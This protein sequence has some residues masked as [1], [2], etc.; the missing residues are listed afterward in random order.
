[1]TDYYRERRNA[2]RLAAQAAEVQ[3]AAKD[4]LKQLKDI[5]QYLY[6]SMSAEEKDGGAYYAQNLLDHAHELVDQAHAYRAAHKAN[7]PP[8]EEGNDD[9]A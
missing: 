5:E 2:E 1:M 3:G 8:K 4:I 9:A 6:W 7:P